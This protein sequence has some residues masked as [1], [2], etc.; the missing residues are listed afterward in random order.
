MS[1][2]RNV[3]RVI[4]STQRKLFN[5]IVEGIADL[6]DW[7]SSIVISVSIITAFQFLKN[8]TSTITMTPSIAYVFHEISGMVY[9]VGIGV[10]I[11]LSLISLV[12][13]TQT[14]STTI[15]INASAFKKRFRLVKTVMLGLTIE[16]SFITALFYFLTDID[17]TAPS[18]FLLSDWD[19]SDLGSMDYTV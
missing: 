3:F 14:I 5:L 8:L 19:D 13:L 2:N 10:S 18:E 17:G 1:S 6:A 16:S 11:G 9:T 12:T 15:R 4:L 7:I